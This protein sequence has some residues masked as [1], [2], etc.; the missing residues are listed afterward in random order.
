[1]ILIILIRMGSSVS[2]KSAISAVAPSLASSLQGGGSRRIR[3]SVLQ[4]TFRWE[5]TTKFAVMVI[6]DNSSIFIIRILS[7]RPIRRIL[8]SLI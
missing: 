8:I 7:C 5:M 6:L 1:M 3:S 2:S 4:A